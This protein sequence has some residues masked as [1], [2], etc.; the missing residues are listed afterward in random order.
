M[1]GQA[2]VV[3]HLS[4]RPQI[5]GEVCILYIQRDTSKI[6]EK[7]QNAESCKEIFKNRVHFHKQP[8]KL[9]K[10]PITIYY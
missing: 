7:E 3:L 5:D 10:L 1:H 2:K 6:Q 8:V 9:S 4:S